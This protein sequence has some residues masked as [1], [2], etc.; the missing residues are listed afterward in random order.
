MAVFPDRIVL[1]NSSDTEAEIVAAIETGGADEIT[2]GELVIGLVD[3]GTRFYTKDANGDIVWLGG[4]GVGPLYINDLLDVDT[5]ANPPTVDQ[6]LVW[7]G[8]NWVPGEGGSSSVVDLDDLGDVS[9]PNPLVGQVLQWSGSAWISANPSGGDGTG[10][11]VFWGGGDF[12]TG[13]SDGEPADG[14]EFTV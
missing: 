1:K 8:A 12:T 4:A 11:L 9:A 5:S 10:G 14:G 7:N 13:T 3:G 6:T 2:Q